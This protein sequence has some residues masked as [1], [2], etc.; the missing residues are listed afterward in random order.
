MGL[1]GFGEQNP[2][3]HSNSPFSPACGLTNSN[4]LSYD[5]CNGSSVLPYSFEDTGTPAGSV[6]SFF[7]SDGTGSSCISSSLEDLPMVSTKC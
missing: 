6:F 7:V 1:A 2:Q 3:A 5:G 4:L